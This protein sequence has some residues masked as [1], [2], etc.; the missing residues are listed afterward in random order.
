MVL[1]STPTPKFEQNQAGQVSVSIVVTNHVDQILSERG[2]IPEHEVRTL[3]IDN[4]LVDT[5]ATFL[6]LPTAMIEQLGLPVD[7]EMNI[8]TAAGRRKAR[9]FREANLIVG[10]RQSTFDCL[11]LTDIDQPLLGVTPMEILGLEPDLKNQKL[12]L[13]PMKEGETYVYA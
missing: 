7:S 12:R 3:T 1:F 9:L 8:K 11:E 4:V 10:G 13:L 2:F 6:S 5:G